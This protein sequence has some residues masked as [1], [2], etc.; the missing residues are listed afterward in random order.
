MPAEPKLGRGGEW[1]AG[2]EEM[3]AVVRAAN[4]LHEFPDR[5]EGAWV[6]L[7][8]P[9]AFLDEKGPRAAARP[10]GGRY[11]CRVDAVAVCAPDPRD[12]SHGLPAKSQGRP[13]LH[14]RIFQHGMNTMGHGR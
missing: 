5:H 1:R 2:S 10:R 9:P 13:A 11:W 3:G 8:I 12:L 4:Q 6:G 7:G 14:Q